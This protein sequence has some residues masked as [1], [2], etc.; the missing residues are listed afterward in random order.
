MSTPTPE[1]QRGYGSQRDFAQGPSTYS[2]NAFLFK[3]ADA[4]RIFDHP[5]PTLVADLMSGPGRLGLRLQ[6]IV[7]H[8]GSFLFVDADPEQIRKAQQASRHPLNK[9]QV[10]DVRKMPE[11]ATESVDIAVA[12]Y[13]IKDLT[14]EEKIPTLREIRRIMKPGKILAVADMVSPSKEAQGW[15]NDQHGMKQGFEWRK[16]A[17]GQCYIPTTEEYLDHL[18]QAGFRA[19]VWDTH[20]SVVDTRTWVASNQINEA[21]L[22]SLN[23]FILDAPEAVKEAFDIKEEDRAVKLKYPLVIIR[24]VKE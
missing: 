1:S 17:E 3:I 18:Q 10:A 22:V 24:A 7:E 6:E 14:N 16:P 11:V 9:F 5:G 19:R 2:D 12:R 15:L 21:Q 4:M 20:I 8:R 23:R 13:S